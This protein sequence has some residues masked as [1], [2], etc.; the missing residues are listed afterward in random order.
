MTSHAS[1]NF[2][3]GGRFQLS[4]GRYFEK[5][6]GLKPCGTA[7]AQT[8]A[9]TDRAAVQ[10]SAVCAPFAGPVTPLQRLRSNYAEQASP[11]HG[12]DIVAD[13]LFPEVVDEDVLDAGSLCLLPGRLQLLP[14][15]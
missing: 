13:K 2:L 9:V 5:P 14:L 15:H 8:F 6:W 1:G 3:S 10:G 11:E 12:E 7:Q 4:T